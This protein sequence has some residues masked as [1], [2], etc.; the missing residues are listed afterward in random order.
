MILLDI[1]LGDHGNGIDFTKE[2]R[3]REENEGIKRTIIIGMRCS[4]EEEL[5]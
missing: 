3:A 2:I 5:E 4:E 1:D